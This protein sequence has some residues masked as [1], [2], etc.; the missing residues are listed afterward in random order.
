MHT[1]I[2]KIVYYKADVHT[3]F[4]WIKNI[5]CAVFFISKVTENF[6]RA[7]LSLKVIYIINVK[8]VEFEN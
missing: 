3:S 6:K 4:N 7:N 2:D 5:N 1:K 8:S